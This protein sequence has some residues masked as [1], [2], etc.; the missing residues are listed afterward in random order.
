VHIIE[1][2]FAPAEYEMVKAAAAQED[3]SIEA[4]VLK[5]ALDEAAII[6]ERQTTPK[7]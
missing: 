6:D 7:R 1:V 4:F 5:A 3:V 2:W